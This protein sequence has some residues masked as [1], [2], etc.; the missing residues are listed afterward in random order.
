MLALVGGWLTNPKA[1]RAELA[2]WVG[3][4]KQALDQSLNEKA[5]NFL[6]AMVAWALNQLVQTEP[7]VRP[8]LDRFK[9]VYV[10]DSTVLSLPPTLAWLWPGCGK[11]GSAS[12]AGLKLHVG[13]ELV[14]GD[15]NWT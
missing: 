12:A 10:L 13:L 1:S 14:G 4:S 2:Q 7:K 6:G 9:G 5:A 15:F 8:L 11:E 3:V